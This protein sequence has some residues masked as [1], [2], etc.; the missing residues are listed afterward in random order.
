MDKH[1]T[2]CHSSLL[3]THERNDAP[4]GVDLDTYGLVIAYGA[5]I[6]ARVVE[7]DQATMPPG[8]GPTAEEIEMLNEWLTCEVFPDTEALAE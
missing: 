8:G 5:R 7:P 6:H 2:G 4:V 3:Q 1:C